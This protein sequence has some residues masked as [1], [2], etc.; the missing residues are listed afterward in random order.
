MKCYLKAENTDYVEE[1]VANQLSL[2][3]S[4]TVGDQRAAEQVKKKFEVAYFVA[5]EETTFK[6]YQAILKLEE[7]H[8]VDI[9]QAYRNDVNCAEFIDYIS[10]DIIQQTFYEKMK[11]ANFFSI[12]F[13]GATDNATKDQE[14]FYVLLFDLH[15]MEKG[16]RDKVEVK[17]Y[18]LGIKNS[19]ASD[20]GSTAAGIK[21]GI[22]QC[23]QDVGLDHYAEKLICFCADGANVNEGCKTGVMVELNGLSCSPWLELAIKESLNLKQLMKCS[24][25]YIYSTKNL[26]K[27]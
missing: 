19:K 5:K 17:L 8:G 24:C 26:Q 23:F 7:M 1:R 11:N 12:L 16:K 4:F 14:G 22:D 3:E 20:G 10:K 15:L 2:I 25:K 21:H 6:K 13:D 18:F 27:N 9:G